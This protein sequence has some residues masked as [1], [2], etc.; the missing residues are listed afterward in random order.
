MP[1]PRLAYL[2]RFQKGLNVF[3]SP[4]VCGDADHLSTRVIL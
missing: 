4:H 3:L 1:G 2:A